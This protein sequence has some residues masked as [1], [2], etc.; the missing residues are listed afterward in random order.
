MVG[1]HHLVSS[2]VALVVGILLAAPAAV[3]A[4]P[5]GDPAAVA[6]ITEL[7]KKA[8][9]AYSQQDYETAKNLL[10]Q[11]LQDCAEAGLDQHPITARTHLH[12]GAVAIVGFNQRDAGIKQFKKA[13]E[14]EPDIKLTKSIVTPE[15]QD[16]FEEAVLASNGGAAPGGEGESGGAAASGQAA[17]G[18]A[19]NAAA[20][21]DEDE[22]PRHAKPKPKPRKKSGDEDEDSGDQGAAKGAGF[23]LGL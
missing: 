7:N 11:A 13:L 5:A 8:L 22:H 4:A 23:Y 15:L 21:D 20:A 19:D 18:G 10:K 12:F 9:A 16:A 14:I 3:T 17:E 2:R 6:K 1:S